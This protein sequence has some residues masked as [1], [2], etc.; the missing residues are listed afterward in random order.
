MEGREREEESAKRRLGRLGNLGYSV[1]AREKGASRKGESLDRA[2][3][4]SRSR[5]HGR[6]AG[7][8]PTN[9]NFKLAARYRRLTRPLFPLSPP[10]RVIIPAGRFREKLSRPFRACCER[11]ILRASGLIV[12]SRL[13]L[14]RFP[15]SIIFQWL[16]KAR[17]EPVSRDYLIGLERRE[18]STILG[19]VESGKE[20]GIYCNAGGTVKN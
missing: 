19:R 11:P 3:T 10:A 4:S 13:P 20:S 8:I 1:A 16:E 9:R 18:S 2:I 15:A 17:N 14:S 5:I 12:S 7:E 6:S